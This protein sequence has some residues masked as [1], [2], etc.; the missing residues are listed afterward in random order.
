M[1]RLSWCP[2]EAPATGAGNV[3]I[4][5]GKDWKS[6]ATPWWGPQILG[7]RSD[8]DLVLR[9]RRAPHLQG[10]NQPQL[11]VPGQHLRGA[12]I[13]REHPHG[14]ASNIRSRRYAPIYW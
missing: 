10:R 2:A 13:R 4:R 3:S 12:E 8:N 14:S 6:T 7:D 9:I 5:E 1:G 11:F